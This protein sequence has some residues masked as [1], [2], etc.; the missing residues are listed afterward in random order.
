M[1]IQFI[2]YLFLLF[3][4]L[5]FYRESYKNIHSVDRTSNYGSCP[6]RFNS[7][8]KTPMMRVS[9]ACIPRHIFCILRVYLK[10]KFRLNSDTFV[11]VMKI[12]VKRAIVMLVTFSMER[13]AHQNLK[14]VRKSSTF[15]LT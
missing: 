9:E 3:F 12:R 6:T 1:I 11:T 4:S 14:P 13:I 15:S 7:H 8:S 5:L 10:Q 2:L